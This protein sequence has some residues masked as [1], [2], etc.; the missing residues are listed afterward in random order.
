[1]F[2]KKNWSRNPMVNFYLPKKSS[3]IQFYLSLVDVIL[4]KVLMQGKS[5]AVAY[6]LCVHIKMSS[7]W[8]EFVNK[9]NCISV[10]LVSEEHK[11]IEF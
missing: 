4:I 6:T 7:L 1:M 3:F 5:I 10:R 11:S 2:F 9:N 8:A